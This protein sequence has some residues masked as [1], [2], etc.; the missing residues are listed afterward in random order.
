MGCPAMPTPPL[1][2]LTGRGTDVELPAS[3]SVNGFMAKRV[4][5]ELPLMVAF[6]NVPARLAVTV[7]A[8]AAFT[9]SDIEASP[10]ASVVS[11]HVLLPQVV[12]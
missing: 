3:K 9:A 8:P 4:A 1:S 7:F 11:E 6:T 12:N 10:L 5:V 2:N